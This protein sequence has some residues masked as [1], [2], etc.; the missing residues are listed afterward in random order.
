LTVFRRAIALAVAIAL[1]VGLQLSAS[2][3]G[4]SSQTLTIGVDHFDPANQ[5][6]PDP[7]TGQPPLGAR[8]FSYTDFFTR[9]VAIHSGDTLHFRVDGAFHVLAMA[10]SESAA[11]TGF[12]LFTPDEE[13]ATGT[14]G[15]RIL[16]G[17][18]FAAAAPNAPP[19][20]CGTEAAPCTYHGGN[21]STTPGAE[22][23]EAAVGRGQDWFVTVDAPSGTYTYFCYIHPGMRGKVKVVQ[24]EHPTTTQSHINTE[25]QAQFLRDRSDALKAEAQASKVR[26]TG[27]EPGERT[28]IVHGGVN[29]PGNH[30]SIIEML[31][32][33]LNLVQGD[34]V[35]FVM[36]NNEPHSFT[37]PTSN[38]S[39]G[40]FQPD[41]SPPDTV[42]APPPGPGAPPE[43]G[44]PGQRPEFITDPG[45]S[46]SGTALT[47]PAALIDSGLLLG[48]G[49]RGPGPTTWTLTT[50]ANTTAT[51]GYN[52]HCV[53]HDFMAGTLDV[54]TAASEG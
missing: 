28:Y 5:T 35:R 14:G 50:N 42:L 27:G 30:V 12:P 13:A 29:S 22:V 16:L 45:D 40:P 6:P 21:P 3:A 31:P 4:E 48:A 20:S 23:V 32:N 53:L 10:R 11:R 1:P 33:H 24:P 54:A 37:F 38:D 8:E 17:P 25:S 46:P 2:A 44:D 15:P 36:Q 19:P 7:A 26:F 39:F 9:S 52:Y 51:S 43:C 49:Y 34:R 41:C 18:A 47:N